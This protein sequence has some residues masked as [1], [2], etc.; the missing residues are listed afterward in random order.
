MRNLLT[1]SLILL[2]VR[3]DAQPM[4]TVIKTQA[5]AMGRAL[6]A[7]DQA[8]FVRYMHPD[9]RKL[10][11]SSEKVRQGMDSAFALFEAMGGK[12]NKISYG[13]PGEIFNFK[14][15][16]QAILPQYTSVSTSFADVELTSMLLAVSM[17]GGK[18]WYFTEPNA[19]RAAAKKADL[20]P[21]SP[22]LVIPPPAQPKITPKKQ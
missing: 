12:V 7:H 15:Q 4:A 10:A 17:D 14:N 5:I 3:V 22:N 2:T 6:V 21:L 1:I 11:G 9:M 18:Q 19:Y 8:T 13:D 16:L 20:P